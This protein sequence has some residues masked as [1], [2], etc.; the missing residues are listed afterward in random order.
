MPAGSPVQVQTAP[1]DAAPDGRQSN[2]TATVFG[3]QKSAYGPAID[4]SKPGVALPFRFAGE[5]PQVAVTGK[6]SGKSVVCEIVDVGP[7]NTNDPYWTTGARPQAESGTDLMNPPRHTNK[8][9]ID[10]TLAAAQA[11]AIDGKGLVDWEFV[12]SPLQPT[13]T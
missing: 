3:G 12:Q 11:I 1:S 10:L 7:W 5:R 2:I 6:V 8:A 13:V 4:D 9:G